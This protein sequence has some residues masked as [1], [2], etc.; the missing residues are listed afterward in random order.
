[1][2]IATRYVEAGK[3]F[4]LY[5]ELF[6]K[7]RETDAKRVAEE[8][9]RLRKRAGVDPGTPRN[10]NLEEKL[11]LNF[12]ER[13]KKE[14]EEEEHDIDS[15]RDFIEIGTFGVRLLCRYLNDPKEASRVAERMKAIREDGK[16]AGLKDDVEVRG[17]VEMSLGIALGS[18][19][20]QGETLSL[21]LS[22]RTRATD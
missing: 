3:A 1:M 13:P 18:L 12:D 19:A 6:E 10:E 2:T 16:E 21:S 4:K 8:M 17:K 7:A 9:K 14:E 22:L 11:E 20:N 15:D 5:L